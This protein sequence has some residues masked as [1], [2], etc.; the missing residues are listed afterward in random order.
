MSDWSGCEIIFGSA[1][2]PATSWPGHGLGSEALRITG[3][4]RRLANVVQAQVEHRHSLET[5]S[6]AGMWW[7]TIAEGVDVRLDSAD[8]YSTFD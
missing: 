7:G 3:E 2:L 8:V 4:E 5:N 6:T 1:P